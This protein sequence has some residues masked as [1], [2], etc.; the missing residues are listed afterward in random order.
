M[1][2]I[3]RR[4]DVE[5]VQH[6]TVLDKI[7]KVWALIKVDRW[8]ASEPA[9]DGRGHDFHGFPYDREEKAWIGND[10]NHRNDKAHNRSPLESE[11]NDVPKPTKHREP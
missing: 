6:S 4:H 8:S 11:Q 3:R 9:A 5:I 1:G 2:E 7:W 10:D